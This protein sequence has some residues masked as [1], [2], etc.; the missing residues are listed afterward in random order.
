VTR[1]SGLLVNCAVRVLAIVVVAGMAMLLVRFGPGFETDERDL[2]PSLGASART[3][4][5]SRIVYAKDFISGVLRGDLGESRALGVPVRELIAERGPT[6]LRILISGSA[7]AWLAALLWSIA[8][9]VFRIPAFA[10]VSTLVSAGLLCLP[11][12]AIAALTLNA[13]WPAEMVLALALA[14][15]IFQVVRG[16]IM[17]VLQHGEVL[18]AR[19]R[20]LRPWRILGWYVLPRIG[21]PMLAWMVATAGLAIAAIVPIE[22]IC[23]VPGLGQLAWKAALA[24]DLPL[25]VV[26]TLLV[27]VVIQLSNAATALV[28]ATA[29]GQ[30]A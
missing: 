22:V 28:P 9:A 3:A 4:I 2:D 5:H 17:Q 26:L 13:G 14:P 18:A 21:G 7:I 6:T 19:S 23:D 30:R 15:R 20:G 27:A 11:T 10:G 25:L 16:L 12:A 24:R 8:L 29:R 1:V